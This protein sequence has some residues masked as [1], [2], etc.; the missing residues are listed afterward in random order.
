[1]ITRNSSCLRSVLIMQWII[2]R[3]LVLWEYSNNFTVDWISFTFTAV[4]IIFRVKCLVISGSISSSSC[5]RRSICALN[6]YFI[7]IASCTKQVLKLFRGFWF[8]FNK[9]ILNYILSDMFFYFLLI[10]FNLLLVLFLLLK[11]KLSIK[12]KKQYLHLIF[13]YTNINY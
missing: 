11:F 8:L 3:G 10:F 6:S 13:L 5:S 12:S 7:F 9:I 2:S 1:M 4:W